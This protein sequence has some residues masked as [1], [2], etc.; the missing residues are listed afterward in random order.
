MQMM[1]IRSANINTETQSI[2]SSNNIDLSNLKSKLSAE[3]NIKWI[4]A[5]SPLEFSVSMTPKDN[6]KY[7]GQEFEFTFT[8]ASENDNYPTEIK[9]TSEVKIV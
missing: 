7:K 5:I 9:C 4:K 6:S 8:L 2:I 3:N 1:V